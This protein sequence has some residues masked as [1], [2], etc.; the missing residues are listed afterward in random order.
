MAAPTEGISSRATANSPAAAGTGNAGTT[1][2]AAAAA[3]AAVV[4]AEE[5]STDDG[6]SPACIEANAIVGDD[7]GGAGAE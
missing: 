1:T 5:F 4:A 3:A 6:G 2:T 7:V